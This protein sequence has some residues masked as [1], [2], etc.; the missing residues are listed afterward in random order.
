MNESTRYAVLLFGVLTLITSSYLA[1]NLA[2][3]P[4]DSS[5]NG[6]EPLPVNE[7]PGEDEID[8]NETEALPPSERPEPD[9]FIGKSIRGFQI[10]FEDMGRAFEII[11]EPSD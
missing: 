7:S 3:T 1:I 5:A 9:S 2:D 8:Q 6:D 4:V 10:M 11:S